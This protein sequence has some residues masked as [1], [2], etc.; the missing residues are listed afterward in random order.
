MGY[1]VTV[2]GWGR[3]SGVVSTC[4]RSFLNTI[5]VGCLTS[6]TSSFFNTMPR[7]VLPPAGGLFIIQSYIQFSTKPSFT[8]FF[9]HDT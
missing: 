5:P 7:V 9:C 8:Y 1:S 3:G 4:V 2:Y 6:C